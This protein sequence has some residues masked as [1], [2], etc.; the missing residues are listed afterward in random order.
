MN[1]EHVVN[2]L[3][4]WLR[5]KVK[6]AGASGVVLGLSGGI[7]SAVVAAIAKKAF[8]DD[9]IAL[10]LPCESHVSDLM[11]AQ[12]LAEEINMRYRI[13]E[14]D[15]AYKL[16]LTQYESYIKLDGEKGRLLRGNIK[17]RLRMT[18]LYY[19]AQARNY[20]V[21]GASNKVELMVGYS[22]KYGDNAVDIQ[23]IGDFLKREVYELAY[24]LNIPQVI[25]DKPPSGGLWKGQTDE[26]EMG[27]SYEELDRYIEYGTGSPEVIEKIE[28]MITSSEH[29]RRQPLIAKIPRD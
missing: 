6:D 13:V 25:I 5:E 19:S 15:N 23:L 17:P 7:D 20:L 10:L 21:L 1:A 9:S 22:T 16:L 29:K 27:V 12:L 14:L 26:G 18:T 2:Y 11:H 24:Y 28:K 3:V 4:N 8:P